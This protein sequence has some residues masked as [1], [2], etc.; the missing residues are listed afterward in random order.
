MDIKPEIYTK[1]WS[2]PHITKIPTPKPPKQK[3]VYYLGEF[4]VEPQ[5]PVIFSNGLFF[6]EKATQSLIIRPKIEKRYIKKVRKSKRIVE[7]TKSKAE[8]LI[9]LQATAENPQLW[10]KSNYL[11]QAIKRNAQNAFIK[12]IWK[13][14]DE[15]FKEVC[16]G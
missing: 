4:P 15:I 5:N 10:F 12:Q 7:I 1:V 3:R 16:V 11:N 6:V 8:I 2:N 14:R 13:Y 9:P